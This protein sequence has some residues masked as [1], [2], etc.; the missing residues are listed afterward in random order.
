MNPT[1]LLKG[2]RPDITPL[3]FVAFLIA[4][5]PSLIVL[6]G[7]NLGADQS[8]ALDDLLKLAGA[9]LGTDVL[10]RGARNYS[11]GKT[12]EAAAVAAGPVVTSARGGEGAVATPLGAG[13]DIGAAEDAALDA[14]ADDAL[15]SDEEELK[16]IEGA[17]VRP[18]SPDA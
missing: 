11:A 10:L 15:P 14:I 17:G 3:A 4:G 9:L 18:D 1:N 12:A 5:V 7:V 8:E 16:G 2:L 13:D 6:F